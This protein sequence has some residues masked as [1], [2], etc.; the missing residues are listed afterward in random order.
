MKAGLSLAFVSV[1][2]I[3][4]MFNVSVFASNQQYTKEDLLKKSEKGRTTICETA[5]AGWTVEEDIL[6]R[7]KIPGNATDWNANHIA[8]RD[9][10]DLCAQI[11]AEQNQQNE[12]PE[13]HKIANNLNDLVGQWLDLGSNKDQIKEQEYNKQYTSYAKQIQDL[14]Q[15]LKNYPDGIPFA[16][17]TEDMYQK[18]IACDGQGKL[19]DAFGNCIDQPQ[20]KAQGKIKSKDSTQQ[21]TQ[22]IV[23]D[24]SQNDIQKLKDENTL[25]KKQIKD[26]QSQIIKLSKII[27]KINM[28]LQKANIK[29]Q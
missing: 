22:N 16:L 6:K 9:L 4:L 2:V 27:D 14:I 15:K 20:K 18:K 17:Q 8:K 25:L 21:S 11:Q 26:L 28:A 1:M 29:I 24:T 19:Y 12:E 13:W 5:K 10:I 23:P 7:G 3:S